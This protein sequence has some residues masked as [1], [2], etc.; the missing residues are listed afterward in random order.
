MERQSNINIGMLGCVSEGKSTLV[1][2]L[3][4]IKTQKH[5]NELKIL[6]LNQVMPTKNI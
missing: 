1:L 3:T 2:K 6:Q 5:S 4:K